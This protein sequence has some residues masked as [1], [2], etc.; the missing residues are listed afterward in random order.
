MSAN[1]WRTTRSIPA[2]GNRPLCR[3]STPSMIK[4]IPFGFP[5]SA[6]IAAAGA[7]TMRRSAR[8]AGNVTM[9]A[10]SN[11]P[12]PLTTPFWKR[13]KDGLFIATTHSGSLATGLAIG[14]SAI[15]T[16]QFAEPPRTSAPYDGKYVV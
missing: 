7:R 8:I 9:S 5:S 3:S 10:L 1:I 2:S 14:S 4:F 13:V 12:P 16:V 11:N 6:A 15:D